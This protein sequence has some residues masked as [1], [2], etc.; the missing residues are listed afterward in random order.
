MS[1]NTGNASKFGVSGQLKR[2]LASSFYLV[3]VMV[4]IKSAAA[5][6][7]SWSVVPQTF[8]VKGEPVTMQALKHTLAVRKH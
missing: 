8:G 1:S 5:S 3:L 4:F 2:A 6:S 7:S